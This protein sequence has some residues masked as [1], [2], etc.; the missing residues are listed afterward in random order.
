MLCYSDSLR[1]NENWGWGLAHY[2]EIF[3]LEPLS[4]GGGI[5]AKLL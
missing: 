4:R 5:E 2:K 3:Q 1:S